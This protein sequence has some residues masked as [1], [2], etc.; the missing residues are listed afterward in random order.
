MRADAGLYEAKQAGR[1]QLKI[2]PGSVS[3]HRQTSPA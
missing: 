2:H 1:G 3:S